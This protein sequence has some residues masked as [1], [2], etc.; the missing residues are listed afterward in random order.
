VSCIRALIIDDEKIC[1]VD[2]RHFLNQLPEVEVV[3]EAQNVAEAIRQ[4]EELEPE[5]IFLDVHMP[6]GNGFSVIENLKNPPKII[7]TTASQD[8]ALRA[9]DVNALDYLVKPVN[10]DRIRKALQRVINIEGSIPPVDLAEVKMPM[11]QIFIKDG[12]RCWFIKLDKLRL[13]ESEGNY[14]RLYFDNEKP[15]VNRA[16]NQME[17]RLPGTRF[18]RANR[19]Q[20]I[21]LEWVREI[22]SWFT[23][24]LIAV[25]QDGT[26]IQMSRRSAQVFKSL[27]GV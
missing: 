9:F 14:V 19:K 23:G 8:F 27:M 20:L 18:F 15:L 6:D 12:E 13:I 5:L 24:G 21:N 16:L 25:L 11:D 22:K 10:E 1:R 4:I 7:F 2:L 17:A 26:E 3:G